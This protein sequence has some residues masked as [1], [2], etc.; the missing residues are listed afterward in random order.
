MAIGL[1]NSIWTSHYPTERMYTLIITARYLSYIHQYYNPHLYISYMNQTSYIQS[2]WPSSKTCMILSPS[3][4]LMTCSLV[5]YIS[6]YSLSM[7]SCV[8]LSI[9]HYHKDT[10]SYLFV[11]GNSSLLASI[12]TM[13]PSSHCL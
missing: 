5:G 1:C 13:T 11:C 2:V 7:T 4:S 10:Y 6:S 9:T 12:Y 3:I 8:S